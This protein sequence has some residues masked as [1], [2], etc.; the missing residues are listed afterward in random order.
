MKNTIH[1]LTGF[2]VLSLLTILSV[3]SA[4]AQTNISKA[5]KDKLAARISKLENV[6]GDD[7]KK[8][9]SNVTPGE[10]RIL[11]CM[12][13]YEDQISDKCDFELEET[14]TNVELTANNL[15]DAIAACKAE[16]T[17]VCGNTTPG[18]GRIAACLMANK[19]TAS[20]TCVDAIGKI[21]SMLA[22]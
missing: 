2:V 11:Y 20:K 9:C 8:F 16:I 12:H 5:I 15:K 6:C 22:E 13:A 1:L 4:S 7:I 10:G 14:A 18:E 17:G 19:A 3:G 21:E